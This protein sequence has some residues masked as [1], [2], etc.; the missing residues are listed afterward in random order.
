[1]QASRG[2]GMA[3]TIPIN[4]HLARNAAAVSPATSASSTTR[5]YHQNMHQ[6]N[7]AS[8]ECIQGG[9]QQQNIQPGQPYMTNKVAIHPSP[10]L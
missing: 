9:L 4:G 3:S 8:T 2:T 1:M 7:N 6:N 5:V 10:M